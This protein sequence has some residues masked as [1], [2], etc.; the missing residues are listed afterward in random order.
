MRMM[1]AR[2]LLRIFTAAET[3]RR[4]TAMSELSLCYVYI[5]YIVL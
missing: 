3:I 1:V 4:G 5:L 2:G